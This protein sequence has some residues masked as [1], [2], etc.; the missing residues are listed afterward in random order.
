[1]LVTARDII[2]LW[3]ARMIMMGLEFTGSIPFSDVYV[4]SVI[5]APDGRRM[6]K[7][8]GT[9]IDPLE[10]IDRSGADAVRFGL[11]AM[12]SSQDVRYSGEKV[13]QGEA[14]AN[15]LYNAARFAI[16]SLE[17][18]PLEAADTGEPAG[19]TAV[20]DRWILSRLA[21]AEEE[22]A[23]RIERYDFARAT[24]ALYDFVYGELCDWYIELVKA[25]LA[26]PRLRATLRFVLRRTLLLAHPIMPFVTEE[27]WPHVREEGEGLLAGTV[28]EPLPAGTR[29]EAAEQTLERVIAATAAVRRWRNEVGAAPGAALAARLDAD[30]YDEALLARIARLELASAQGEGLASIAVPG[31]SIAILAGVDLAAHEQRLERERARLDAEIARARAK[32]ENGAFV[33]NAPREVVAAEREKLERLEREREALG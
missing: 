7:S 8:L 16:L 13:R 27:L 6:S 14:L 32:L 26:D 31:G 22:I 24:Q 19:A 28:R 23:G 18:P 4:H 29:D 1:M 15:K 33:A 12:S 10:E 17:G 5:Q 25:R 20:E 11:L 2:F 21:A 30:G 3:V 9:G